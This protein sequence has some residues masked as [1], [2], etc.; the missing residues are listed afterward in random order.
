MITATTM[1]YLYVETPL[2]AGM[3]SGLSS[4]DLPIQRERT[5]QYPMIQ[6]SGIK[7]KLRSVAEDMVE[8]KT[9]TLT[10]ERVTIMFGP[11]TTGSDHAGALI[12]GDARILLFPV[13]SL[14]GVFAYTTSY[15]VL[16]RFMRDMKRGGSPVEWHLEEKMAE[17]AV[18]VT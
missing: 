14:S 18:H 9:G 16:S 6:G 5:T 11:K 8:R 7:G 4:I 15:D 1:L 10:D 12:A 2:H 17:D 3:G 13:R